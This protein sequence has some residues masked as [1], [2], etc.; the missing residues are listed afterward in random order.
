MLRFFSSAVLGL[1]LLTPAFIAPTVLRADD[2]DRDHNRDRVY[3][4][5]E[6]HDE[7]HWD[8]REDH[9]YRMWLRERHRHYR[10]FNRLNERDQQAYWAWRH[11]HS[12]GDLHIDI[13]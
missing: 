12:D 4:D 7:H 11:E 9:A 5:R 8:S 3:Q 13:H 1:A 2:H 6:H 10:E